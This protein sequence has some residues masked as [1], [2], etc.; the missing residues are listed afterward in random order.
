LSKGQGGN[1]NRKYRSRNDIIADMLTVALDG[2]AMKMQIMYG[3]YIS[4]KQLKTDYLP[5][6]LR[7]GLLT[8][9]KRK[10]RYATTEKGRQFLD[11][12]KLLKI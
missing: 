3:A 8:F 4:Y 10:L 5:L 9:D 1:K 7:N 6:L 11:A 2:G 12:H